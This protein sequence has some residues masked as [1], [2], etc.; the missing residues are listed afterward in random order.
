MNTICQVFT[1]GLSG[2]KTVQEAH[3]RYFHKGISVKTI[4][5]PNSST[6]MTNTATTAAR[7]AQHT[8]LEAAAGSDRDQVTSSKVHVENLTWQ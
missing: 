8:K 7:Q 2:A 6:T 3:K 4:E 5:L 1:L